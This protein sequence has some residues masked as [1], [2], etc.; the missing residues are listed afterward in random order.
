MGKPEGWRQFGTLRNKWVDKIKM[1]LSGNRLR[2]AEW[3][4]LAQDRD[5][6]RAVVNVVM[7]LRVA[8]KCGEFFWLAEDRLFLRRDSDALSVLPVVW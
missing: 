5:R 3:I 4:N 2:D 7:N 8:L 1:D 6:W